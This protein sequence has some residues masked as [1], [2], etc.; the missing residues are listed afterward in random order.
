MLFR[1]RLGITLSGFP[2][3]LNVH[4]ELAALDL[5]FESL[6]VGALLKKKAGDAGDDAGFVA[7]DH[8]YDCMVFNQ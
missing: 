1:S 8:G 2:G 3:S 6:N 5:L 4:A 7:A